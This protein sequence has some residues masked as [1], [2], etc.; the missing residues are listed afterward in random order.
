MNVA[1]DR[2]GWYLNKG[3][4][5]EAVIAFLTLI[6]LGFGYVLHQDR[7]STESEARIQNLKETDDRH[8]KELKELKG[9]IIAQLNRIEARLY[10]N[11]GRK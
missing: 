9:E 2:R 5:V 11:N 8:E 4:S 3:I 6:G 1:A 10:E 7:R